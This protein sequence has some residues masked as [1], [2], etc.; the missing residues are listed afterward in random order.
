MLRPIAQEQVSLDIFA[1][2]KGL[3]EP[4]IFKWALS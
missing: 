4:V 3:F 1:P 2:E